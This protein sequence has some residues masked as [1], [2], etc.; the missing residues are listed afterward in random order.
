MRP[1]A[2]RLLSCAAITWHCVNQGDARVGRSWGH[3]A[4]ITSITRA[5]APPVPT[6][7]TTSKVVG[8][9]GSSYAPVAVC[10]AHLSG[11]PVN[12]Q[13]TQRASLV[14]LCQALRHPWALARS[15]WQTAPRCKALF[16][17]PTQRPR[18]KT[19]AILVV[20]GPICAA[21]VDGALTMASRQNLGGDEC[22]E[23]IN[24]RFKPSEQL[25]PPQQ[26]VA[27]QARIYAVT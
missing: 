4:S 22:P 8:I 7:P 10:G 5:M 17:R 23:G 25:Q 9:G 19:S 24:I 13:L 26:A 3:W 14:P 18:R 2:C 6:S 12:W 15:N 27:F 1:C 16:V 11:L 21:S 20:G